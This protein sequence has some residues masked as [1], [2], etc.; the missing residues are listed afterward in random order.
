MGREGR[1]KEVPV[2]ESKG[3]REHQIVV[4]G[5]LHQILFKLPL[6]LHIVN[7]RLEALFAQRT[8]CLDLKGW[9]SNRINIET[10]F[11]E[12]NSRLTLLHSSRQLKQNWWRHESVKH[13]FLYV[14]RQ[15]GQ[16]GGGDPDLS[17]VAVSLAAFVLSASAVPPPP[18]AALALT[19]AGGVG[20]LTLSG[21]TEL[22]SMH[23]GVGRGGP[24][25]DILT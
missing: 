10:H 5:L 19:W 14:P 25:I 24:D 22:T 12:V 1:N 15:M 23:S 18:S 11:V 4:Q 2:A 9:R 13:L 3:F 6:A 17:S 16:L 8:F 20:D 21:V 7:D